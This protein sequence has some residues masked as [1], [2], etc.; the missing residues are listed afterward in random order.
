[1]NA[2]RSIEWLD[3]GIVRFQLDHGVV[4]VYFDIAT[5]GRAADDRRG[6]R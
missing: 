1:M 3:E 5:I 6:R 4:V 2:F